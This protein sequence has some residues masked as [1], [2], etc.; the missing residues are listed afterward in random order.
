MRIRVHQTAR[1]DGE[2]L[3]WVMALIQDLRMTY[4]LGQV[5]RDSRLGSLVLLWREL[6]IK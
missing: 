3:F 4:S 1:R 6:W 5:G 2:I